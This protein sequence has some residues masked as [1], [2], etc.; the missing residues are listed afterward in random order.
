MS[1]LK[2]AK[3]LCCIH[4]FIWYGIIYLSIYSLIIFVFVIVLFFYSVFYIK[5]FVCAEK[6][7]GWFD[8][9]KIVMLWFAS[10]IIMLPEVYYLN[11]N[12]YFLNVQRS[13][14]GQ[15]YLWLRS[16][17]TKILWRTPKK[18][19]KRARRRKAPKEIQ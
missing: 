9:I 19:L 14:I 2:N 16:S 18:M 10:H 3:K 6:K 17:S 15:P 4:L 7:D 13:L 5:H 12:S 8:N 11:V 1:M